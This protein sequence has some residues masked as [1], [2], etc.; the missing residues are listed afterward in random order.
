MFEDTLALLTERAAAVP[1]LLV[2]ED[3]HWADTSTLDLVVFLAHN[4]DNRPV[5]LL[6]TYRAD[7]LSSAERMRRLADGVR[8]S[9]S[10]VVLELG[11][12]ADDELTALL[13]ARAESALSA[14]LTAAI[15]TRS[16]GNPFFAEELLA[17][18]GGG[19]E[20]PRGL[21]ELLLQRVAGLDQPT[22]SVL[23]VAAAAGRE[24]GYA[25][26]RPWPGC[27]SPT[28]ASRCARPS[29]TASSSPSRR[30]AASVSAMR[31]WRR[32]STR[33][34]SPE[35][36]R[37]CTRGSPTCSQARGACSRARAAL[38]GGGSQL[39]GARRLGRGRPPGGGSVRAGG[40]ARTPRA[41]AGALGRRA[42]RGRAVKLELAELCSWSAELAS[43][44]GSAPR[45]VELQRRAIELVGEGD[46]QRAALLYA[47]L[48]RYLYEC[49]KDDAGLAA[50]GHAVEL[51]PAQPPSAERAEVLFRLGSGLLALALRG[52]ARRM[53][54]SAR[55]RSCR[56]RA[57]GRVPGARSPGQ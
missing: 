53:P 56:R 24:V 28:C 44:T 27:R 41:G 42:G 33:R 23:R 50:L 5:L 49:G 40:G 2:L 15:V 29:S 39:G 37:S 20:L 46:P 52:V 13:A 1:V 25:L 45:A 48:F 31:C 7:E 21:R 16:E 51:V 4:L 6:A 36:A 8:R 43:Q 12:L 17:V 54:G 57:P 10:G 32:R 3:L 22:Q 26:L 19:G 38:G 18:A 11:P 34:S 30:R 35:S 9:G 55:G 14:G 47:R